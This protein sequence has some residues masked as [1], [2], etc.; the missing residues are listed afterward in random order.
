[1]KKQWHI[2]NTNM[3]PIKQSSI[4]LNEKISNGNNLYGDRLISKRVLKPK[5]ATKFTK[6]VEKQPYA[7]N[8]SYPD[9][10]IAP[11]LKKSF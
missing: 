9:S 10:E 1:M 4:R 8:F 5:E 2:A 6:L 7:A 11:L 3:S